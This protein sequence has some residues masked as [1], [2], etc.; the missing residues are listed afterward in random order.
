MLDR[1]FIHTALLFVAIVPTVVA[2]GAGGDPFTV[3]FDRSVQIGSQTLPSGT[4]T[5]RQVTSAAKSHVLEFSSDSTK[6]E[7]TFTEIPSVQSTA[8]T[9]TKAVLEDEGDGARLSRIWVQGKNYGYEFPGKTVPVTEP[10]AVS[11]QTRA[12][13]PQ[14]YVRQATPS[15]LAEV[16]TAETPAP[17][18][19]ALQAQAQPQPE[20]ITAAPQNPAP[21]VAQTTPEPVTNTQPIPATALGWASILFA[22]LTVGAAGWFLFL[23]SERSAG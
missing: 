10:A 11:S 18:P 15:E 21:V 1:N 19:A 4:Y 13:T 22:G 12:D 9:E 5:V 14:N 2:Q 3:K 8:P 7:T 6:L 20:P 23:R 17:T 16:P